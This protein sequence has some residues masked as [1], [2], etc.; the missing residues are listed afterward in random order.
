[1]ILK[2]ITGKTLAEAMRKAQQ[3]C[4]KD[5]IL[6]ES[7]QDADGFVL[8]AARPTSPG[9]PG[10]T[11]PIGSIS[12]RSGRPGFARGFAR[13][14]EPALRFGISPGLLTTVEDALIGTKVNV[15]REGDPALPGL[16]ARMLGSLVATTCL[17]EHR[18]VA[19]VGPTG[20]GKTTTLAKLAA[21]AVRER[22]ERVVLLT[23]DTWRIAGV[24]QLR[25]FAEFLG[26]P[27]EAAFT[28]LALEILLEKHAKADRIFVDT[29]G[30]SPFDRPAI[31]T[32]RR[33]LS[34]RGVACALCLPAATRR[35]DG[36][37]VLDAFSALEPSAGIITKWDETLVPGEAISVFVERGIPLSHV[38]TGQNV[39]QDLVCAQ[40]AAISAAAFELAE[41]AV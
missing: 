4:G 37:A 21:H 29:S 27:C 23:V 24:E 15:A 3:E 14:C 11:P 41:V 6:I 7:S 2:R 39:P 13:V 30:R 28:P 9:R 25:S 40:A 19:L 17:D 38:T 33:T 22:G 18:I 34:G 8:I 20:V 35:G 5:A 16:A 31:A 32:L 10:H 12:E 26:V 36:L 1:M